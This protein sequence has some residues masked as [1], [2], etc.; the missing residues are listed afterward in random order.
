[1][2]RANVGPSHL[3]ELLGLDAELQDELLER[4]AVDCWSVRKL[5]AEVRRLGR[6]ARKR[7]SDPECVR[8][9]RALRSMIDAQGLLSQV[10]RLGGVEALE[11][12][13]LLF[14]ARALSQ[15]AHTLAWH[16]SAIVARARSVAPDDFEPPH[17]P[18][19][20]TVL[21]RSGG[22]SEATGTG[23]RS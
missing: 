12:E 4:L 5:K 17:S 22:Q 2:T 11:A 8:H 6:A 18:R 13:R 10:E 16:L 9:L 7:G 21:L 20:S 14:A 15:Q 3:R 1:M 19:L 23:L